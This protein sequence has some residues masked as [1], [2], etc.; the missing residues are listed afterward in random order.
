VFF[1]NRAAALPHGG[2]DAARTAD[3]HPLRRQ[4]HITGVV[5]RRRYHLPSFLRWT[6]W[7]I[8]I[9]RHAAAISYRL[10]SNCV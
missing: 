3:C 6:C 9:L 7:F 2:G 5:E 1:P 4:W 8:A 10:S